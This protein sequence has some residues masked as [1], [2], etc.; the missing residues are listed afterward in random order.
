MRVFLAALVV[1]MSITSF[2]AKAL[3]RNVTVTEQDDGHGVILARGDDLAVSLKTTSGTGY[4]WKVSKIDSSIIEQTGDPTYDQSSSS[5]PGATWNE[6]ITF[7]AK[8]AGAG[9]LELSYS[10]PWETNKPPEKVFTLNVIVK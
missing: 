8:S 10:R 6:V 5:T 7:S 4:T 9:A 1:F 2:A 3:A